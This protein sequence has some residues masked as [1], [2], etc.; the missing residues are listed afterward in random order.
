MGWNSWDSFGYTVREDEVKANADYMAAHMARFG[1]QYI[2]VDIEWYTPTVKT[3]GYIPDPNNVTLDRFGRFVP[4]VKRFPS[5]ANGAGFKALADYVHGKGLRF[6]IHI[7]RGIPRQAVERNLPISGSSHRAA[8]VADRNN[9]CKWKGM[10]DTY[11]VDMSKPGAQDYYNSIAAL[12]ASWGVDYVKADDMS[13]PYQAAEI[14]ALSEALRGTGRPIVL[15]LSPGPAPL[16]KAQELGKYA[17]LWRIS[18][19]FWDGWKALRSQ[20]ELTRAWWPYVRPGA[21]PDA[22]MLPLGHIGIRAEIGDDRRTN[23]TRDEQYTLMTLWAIFRSP[24]MMGGDL[25]GNDSFTL[26]LLT[27]PEVLNVN[28]HSTGNRPV[29]A[30]LEKVVWTARPDSGA[31]SYIAIFNLGDSPLTLKYGWQDLGLEA[32]SYRLRDLWQH[33][34]LGRAESLTVTLPGHGAALFRTMP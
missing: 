20:F 27:N 3:H 2:V 10:A 34:D 15:S 23:F 9:V 5:S 1:W 4:A 26:A 13:S 7:M 29:I 21:W 14:R 33:Q 19:D 16:D 6:G 22:D 24:L 31:G 30:D 28:Q 32:A 12:Y 8:E 17:Q 18:G 25:P 11:G